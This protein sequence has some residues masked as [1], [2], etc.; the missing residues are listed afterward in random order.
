MGGIVV[1]VVLVADRVSDIFPMR[2]VLHVITGRG[3]Y[4]YVQLCLLLRLNFT[5]QSSDLLYSRS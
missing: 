1:A 4:K 3:K 5:D 2:N